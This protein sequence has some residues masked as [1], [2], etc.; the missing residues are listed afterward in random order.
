MNPTGTYWARNWKKNTVLSLLYE[1]RRKMKIL[2]TLL[3]KGIWYDC[4]YLHTPYLGRIRWNKGNS[5]VFLDSIWRIV[6]QKSK[7]LYAPTTNATEEIMPDSKMHFC[8]AIDHE[9]LDYI[10]VI[11]SLWHQAW[12]RYERIKARSYLW[13]GCTSPLRHNTIR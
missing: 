9:E 3:S 2:Y 4:F 7:C 1:G 8:N 11:D 10:K 6:A 5:L 13:W 12:W